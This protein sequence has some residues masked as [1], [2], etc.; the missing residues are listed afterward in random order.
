MSEPQPTAPAE[1]KSYVEWLGG[2]PKQ[3]AALQPG[4]RAHLRRWRPGRS[5]LSPAFW[6][7]YVTR[8]DGDEKITSINAKE[9]ERIAVL[10]AALAET[11]GLHRSHLEGGAPSFGRALATCGFSEARLVRLLEARDEQR[12]DGLLKTAGFL[13]AK[14][15]PFVTTDLVHFACPL[16]DDALERRRH[17]IARDYYAA[18]DAA[19][20]TE[21]EG[22]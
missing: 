2:L 9:L 11:D 7:L 16:G 4:P 5:E 8:P 1:P 17:K 19:A 13:A 22:V 10:L 21:K 3:V 14:A 20:K 12:A 6:R 15:Q 18:L